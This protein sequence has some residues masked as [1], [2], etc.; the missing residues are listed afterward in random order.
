MWEVKTSETKYKGEDTKGGNGHPQKEEHKEVFRRLEK[1]CRKHGHCRRTS[2][3]PSLVSADSC[4]GSPPPITEREGDSSFLLSRLDGFT[5]N[6]PGCL[7]S[8]LTLGVQ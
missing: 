4:T 3:L 1:V 6:G 2:C 5:N 7:Y 8:R